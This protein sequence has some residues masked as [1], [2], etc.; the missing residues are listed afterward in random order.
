MIPDVLWLGRLPYSEALK[1]QYQYGAKARTENKE[2]I[3]GCEH[4]QTITFGKRGGTLLSDSSDIP[5][6]KTSRGGLA[7]AHE[8]GQLLIYPII[9]LKRRELSVRDWVQGVQNCVCSWL[10]DISIDVDQ[11]TDTGVWVQNHKLVSI[12]FQIKDG[13]SH[14]GLAVNVENDLRTFEQIVACGIKDVQLTTLR[15]LGRSHSMHEVFTGIH[16]KL[17]E[18]LK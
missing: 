12:G 18:W 10:Q 4:P 2:Y 13:I 15:N 7:T 9:N 16:T 8:P 3:L 14:H 6:I 5:V 17:R 1:F 11:N